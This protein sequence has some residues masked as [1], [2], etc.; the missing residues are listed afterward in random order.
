MSL[1]SRIPKWWKTLSGGDFRPPTKHGLSG[2]RRPV[3]KWGKLERYCVRRND[4]LPHSSN[5][6][7]PTGKG[8]SRRCKRASEA[9]RSRIPCKKRTRNCASGSHNRNPAFSKPKPSSRR[10]KNFRDLGES[11]E[12]QRGSRDLLIETVKERIRVAGVSQACPSLGI[13]QAPGFVL[14]IPT[15]KAIRPV[16][17]PTVAAGAFSFQS[18]TPESGR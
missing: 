14:P 11:P 1:S 3:R 18:G 17:K 6:A 5:G 13:A 9:G 15:A 16:F 8:L 4:I 7:T 12:K 10:K 2:K